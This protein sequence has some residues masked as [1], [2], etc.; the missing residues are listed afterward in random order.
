[1]RELIALRYPYEQFAPAAALACEALIWCQ[2]ARL[3]VALLS[4]REWA[5][6]L[7]ACQYLHRA[8]GAAALAPAG[9]HPVYA[10]ILQG[11]EQTLPGCAGY[12]F[13]TQIFNDDLSHIA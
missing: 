8:G 5:H 10:G 4:R 13:S 11:I 9:M 7:H 12:G 1:M 6:V 2:S 3:A